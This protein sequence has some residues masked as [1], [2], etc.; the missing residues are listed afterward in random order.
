MRHIDNLKGNKF[1]KLTVNGITLCENCHIWVH[2]KENINNEFI[3][4][5]I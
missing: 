4:E 2:G 1:G 3:K 5:V